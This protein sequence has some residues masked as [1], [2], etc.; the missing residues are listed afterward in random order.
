MINV[1]HWSWAA[2][3]MLM[4]SSVS[5]AGDSPGVAINSDRMTTLWPVDELPGHDPGRLETLRPYERG[6]IPVVF[7]HGLW[8]SPRNWD[9]MIEDLDRDPALQT[10][11]QFWTYRYASGDSILYSAHLL[12]QSLRG[13]RR[14]CDP[15]GSDAAFDRMVLVGHSLGGILAK[16]MVQSGGPL[17]WQTV[18]MRSLD[19]VIAPTADRQLLHQV[20]FYKPVQ[21]VRRLIFV[22]TPHR[23]SPLATGTLGELGTRLCWRPNRFHQAHDVLL[24][25]NDPDLFGHESRGLLATSADELAFRNPLLLRFC[26]L[27]LDSSIRSHSVIADLRDPPRPDGTDGLVPYASSHLEGVVSELLVHGLHICV[28]QPAVIAEVRRIL[29]E[30]LANESARY[31]ESKGEIQ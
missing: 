26:D 29:I 21:E 11:Y 22:A 24:S 19:D 5:A 27:S 1:L 20:F 2:G 30:H 18:C 16:L 17:L 13:A 10:R 15:A 7:I 23:G 31:S 9:R 6:K 8:G 25:R 14:V 4:V 12:R 3:V 28:N